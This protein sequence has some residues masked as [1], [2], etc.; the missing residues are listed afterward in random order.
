MA[1]RAC[2][3][4]GA[5]F[6]APPSSKKIACSPACASEQKRRSHVGK[7]HPWSD[8]AKE[9]LAAKGQTANLQL[10]TSAARQSPIAGPFETNQEAK[11]WWLVDLTTERRYELRNLRKFC[12]DNSHLFAPD[13][14]ENAYAGLRQVQAWL[15]G[16]KTRTVSRWKNWTLARPAEPIDRE[17]DHANDP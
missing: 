2:V 5:S 7:P 6:D 10:G 17:A 4:C 14:W 9:R 15:M 12:R 3:V 11:R 1:V 16:K 13:P 8:A